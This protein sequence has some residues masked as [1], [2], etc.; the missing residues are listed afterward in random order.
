[1]AIEISAKL[2]ARTDD[3]IETKMLFAAM[4]EF[5]ARHTCC[6][7][8]RCPR[9]RRVRA[10]CLKTR[11]DKIQRAA[12]SPKTGQHPTAEQ[13]GIFG[14]FP[15]RAANDRRETGL[16]YFKDWHGCREPNVVRRVAETRMAPVV[17]R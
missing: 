7:D 8:P 17:C 12:T 9:M 5:S 6:P 14:G 16:N 13:P 1:M 3:V 4:H 10:D 2:L 15:S 11:R